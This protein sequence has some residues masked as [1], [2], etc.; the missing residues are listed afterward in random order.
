M[1]RDMILDEIRGMFGEVPR[2]LELLPDDMLALEWPLL[3]RAEIEGGVIP[4]KYRQLI[5]LGM[6]AAKGCPYCVFWHTE[7]AK[8]HG[9]TDQ[10]LENAVHYA[11]TSAGWSTYI[12]GM[13]IS[14]EQ[15]KEE[16]LRACEHIRKG[17]VVKASH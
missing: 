10:E 15:F 14:L 7:M 2:F 3:K 4:P 11:K 16:V 13:E 9:A 6:A 12:H 17:E 5:G 1:S 8:L